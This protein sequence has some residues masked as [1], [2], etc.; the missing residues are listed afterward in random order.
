MSTNNLSHEKVADLAALAN[1]IIPA[2]AIDAGAAAVDAG[3]RLAT[4][5][6]AGANAALYSSGLN[7][8]A[9]A[10]QEKYARGISEL[11]P[12]EI[13]ELVAIVREFAPAFFKQLRMDVSA[14]YL[15]D[16][17]VWQRIGFP[18]AS[19]VTGG[20][21][22]F[23]QPQ[24]AKVTVLNQT[25]IMNTPAVLPSVENLSREARHDVDRKG[26]GRIIQRRID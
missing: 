14:L 4:K 5:I 6:Q 19:A 7:T 20:Y 17:V 2:D 9:A 1:G 23:D 22:D 21:P 25:F 11:A 15:S 16:P 13:H 24:T 18:G 26:V 12:A 3:T 8:A 10:A